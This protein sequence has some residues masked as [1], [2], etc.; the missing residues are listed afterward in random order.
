MDDEFF[1]N[2]KEEIRPFFKHGSGHG[3]DHTERVYNNALAI[4]VGEDVDLDVI[5]SSALMHD[6]CR[7][8][9]EKEEVR[10]HAESG[11]E[12]CKEILKK[13]GFSEDKIEKVAYCI[14]VHRYSTGIVPETIEAKILQDADRLDA[15]GA[16]CIARIFEYGGKRGRTTFNPSDLTA[17]NL[18]EEDESSLYHFYKKIFKITPDKFHTKRAREIAEGRYRFVQEFV[19]RFIKEWEGKL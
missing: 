13:V 2:L 7:E 11:S 17:K 15:L 6:I 12:W 4:S 14:K 18:K 8:M 1:E 3:F 19:D 9:E 16:I 10:C 5:K